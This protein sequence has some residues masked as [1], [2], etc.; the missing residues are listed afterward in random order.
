MLLAGI[1]S[2]IIGYFLGSI[3]TAYLVSKYGYGIDIRKVGS[4][5]VGGANAL[6]TMGTK[7]GLIVVIV[8]VGKGTVAVLIAK[9][10]LKL[11]TLN[12]FNYFDLSYW[13]WLGLVGIAAVLGHC[14]PVWLKFQGGKGWATTIGFTLGLGWLPFLLVFI[15]WVF[16]V[17]I[18]GFTSL[19]NILIVILLPF[20]L[21]V[22]IPDNTLFAVSL[23]FM[24]IIWWRHRENISRLLEGNERR[25]W[26]KELAIKKNGEQEKQGE[27]KTTEE[28]K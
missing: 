1:L 22:A 23:L 15:P 16:I 6:R 21:R 3:P 12:N 9:Y 26:K 25:I 28:K 17:L 24:P 5:N 20:A 2:I 7:A 8:D 11:P 19:A 27:N 10:L 18:S 14:Y 13:G 4:G